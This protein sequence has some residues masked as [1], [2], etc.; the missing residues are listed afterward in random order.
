MIE[1]TTKHE[2]PLWGM[3]DT[4]FGASSGLRYFKERL[5]FRPYKVRWIWDLQI[6]HGLSGW[7]L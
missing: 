4:F 6:G 1:H 5:G 3:Y 7:K 2:V